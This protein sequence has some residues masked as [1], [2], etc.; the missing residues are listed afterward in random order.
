MEQSHT[1]DRTASDGQGA[2]RPDVAVSGGSVP[3]GP[4]TGPAVGRTDPTHHDLYRRPGGPS[5]PFRRPSAEGSADAPP[6]GKARAG[7]LPAAD[8]PAGPVLLPLLPAQRPASGPQGP[9]TSGDSAGRPWE[10][11]TTDPDRELPAAQP[12]PQDDELYPP[13]TLVDDLFL[14][15]DGP[16]LP[17]PVTAAHPY[18]PDDPASTQTGAAFAADGYEEVSPI[19]PEGPFAAGLLRGGVTS[20]MS[21]TIRPP[22]AQFAPATVRSGRRILG[23]RTGV[24]VAVVLAAM[25][26]LTGA[27]TAVL[28]AGAKLTDI[29]R[30]AAGPPTADTEGGSTGLPPVAV[31]PAPAGPGAAASPEPTEIDTAPADAN[32][33]SAARNGLDEATFQL[34]NGTTTVDLRAADLGADLYRISTP[35]GSSVLPRPLLQGDR[36][37]LHLVRSG[38]DGPGAVEI[39]LNSQVR[40]RLQI[41][42]GAA[43]HVIDMSDGRLAGLDLAGGA[44]RIDVTLPRARGTVKIRMTGGVNQF[45]VNTP[46][47]TPVRL[48]IGSGA[49]QVVLDGQIHRGIAPGKEFSPNRWKSVDDRVDLD[50]VAGVGTF[51]LSRY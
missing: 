28:T 22:A 19:D 34:V 38:Q 32:T 25:L 11:P 37:Q 18:Q 5:I 36:V 20:P 39:T 41:T 6:T 49:A 2:D 23:L 27:V 43:A 51:T 9:A 45:A 15:D 14:A 26:V 4:N 50:A 40:W 21:D 30:T 13:F 44:T 10:R 17:I 8:E 7:A 12:G 47:G 33:A 48:R 42:G 1:P 46:P 16:D 31:D 24:F 3:T 35:T 29:G